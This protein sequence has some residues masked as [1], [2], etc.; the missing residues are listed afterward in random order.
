MCKERNSKGNEE[1]ARPMTRSEQV[2][3]K[4]QKQS[5]RSHLLN[6]YV[7]IYIHLLNQ[8]RSNFFSHSSEKFVFQIQI[9][10]FAHSE[11]KY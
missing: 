10:S 1:G 7:L 11:V 9:Q 3:S 6:T 4:I 5:N 2:L 8:I